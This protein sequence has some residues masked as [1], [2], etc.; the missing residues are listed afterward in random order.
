MESFVKQKMKRLS[1]L[2][3]RYMLFLFERGCV[4]VP[5]E[6]LLEHPEISKLTKDMSMI[7]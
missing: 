3:E 5:L 6:V 7:R 1:V 4:E 2:V